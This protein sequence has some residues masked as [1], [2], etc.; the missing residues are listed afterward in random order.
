MTPTL[1]PLKRALLAS[2]AASGTADD[3]SMTIFILSHISLMA[4]II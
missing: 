4:S 1:L 2:T 3:G